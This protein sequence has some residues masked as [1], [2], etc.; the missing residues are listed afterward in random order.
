MSN[1]ALIAMGLFTIVCFSLIYH[2]VNP[3]W[4]L[5]KQGEEHFYQGEY[6]LAAKTYTKAIEKGLPLSV[7]YSHLN[8]SSLAIKTPQPALR[9]YRQRLATAEGFY[10]YRGLIDLLLRLRHFD[11]V[12][13]IYQDLLEE[14]P[15]TIILQT[16]LA[17]LL[18]WNDQL[19]EAIAEYHKALE[20]TDD[21]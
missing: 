15:D 3:E 8:T 19:P 12:I 4:I 13:A 14:F 5:Y 17:R 20:T 2:W 11:E 9:L 16:S 10:A 1:K 21:Y 18:T 6:S 7:T